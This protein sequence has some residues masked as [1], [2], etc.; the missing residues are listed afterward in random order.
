MSSNE[1]KLKR[2]EKILS[3]Q[4]KI[5]NAKLIPGYNEKIAPQ[6]Y[7]LSVEALRD[8]SV[9]SFSISDDAK[10]EL[11]MSFFYKTDKGSRFFFGKTATC[12]KISLKTE[13][14][15]SSLSSKDLTT[16]YLSSS[17]LS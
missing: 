17:L 3:H 8:I 12:P 13:L 15:R 1:S 7:I 2:F 6:S 11:R 16:L 14:G 10:A 4:R 9:K 5:S